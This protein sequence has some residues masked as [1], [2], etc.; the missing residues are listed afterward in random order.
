MHFRPISTDEFGDRTGKNERR[1]QKCGR[2]ALRIIRYG[3]DLRRLVAIVGEEA[4]TEL[5]KKYLE[6]AD[7]F[8]RQI[9]LA[10]R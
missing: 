2:S 4:L 8:E 1:S 7:E 6:F 9:H 5:D 3:R 10:R